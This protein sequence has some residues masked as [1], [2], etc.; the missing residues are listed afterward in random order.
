MRRLPSGVTAS[1]V[2]VRS[3]APPGGMVPPTLPLSTT[4]CPD[5]NKGVMSTT[6]SASESKVGEMDFSVVAVMRTHLNRGPAIA[7]FGDLDG[8]GGVPG[9]GG[10]PHSCLYS[11]SA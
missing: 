5:T 9:T 10:L 6:P 1:D 8:I 4:F 3:C 2:I 11:R 7:P